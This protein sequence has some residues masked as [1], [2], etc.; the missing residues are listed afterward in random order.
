MSIH[1][2]TIGSDPEMFLV[3]NGVP[4]S[5]IGIIPGS[6]KRPHKISDYES[7]QVDNV[8]IEFNLKPSRDHE[9]FIKSLQVCYDWSSKHLAAIDPSISLAM[10]ASLEFPDDQL[11]SRGA[12]M[13]G[14]DPDFNAWES[15]IPNQAPARGSNLRSCGGHIHIGYMS[16]EIVDINRLVRL[17][18]KNV[19]I[20][21]AEICG[22]E[23]RR[24]LYGKAGAYR[25]KPY[26]V[27]YR[28]PS[29]AWLRSEESIKE[30][31]ERIQLSVNDYNVGEDADDSVRYFINEKQTVEHE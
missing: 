4:L 21:C 1:V 14:C 16:T 27:E 23:R 9:E 29:I 25:E 8:A 7:V 24:T 15:G 5:S 26:G 28:T 22:D 13:F 18:D 6:K 11:Q 2:V 12:K 30:V 17:L 3:R 10:T 19:G 20:Y 31:F